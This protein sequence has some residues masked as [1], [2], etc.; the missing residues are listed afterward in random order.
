M[1]G[2]ANISI[3]PHMAW[4]QTFKELFPT[5]IKKK[6]STFKL[7]SRYVYCIG[8]WNALSL[9]DIIIPFTVDRWKYKLQPVQTYVCPGLE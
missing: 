2:V 1:V 5:P 9:K 8:M 4:W 6:I 3:G 7:C